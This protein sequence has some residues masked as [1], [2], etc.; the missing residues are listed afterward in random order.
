MPHPRSPR[1]KAGSFRLAEG[2]PIAI[3]GAG[4]KSFDRRLEITAARLR[5]GIRE[6]CGAA[7]AIEG[8]AR[9]E[10]LGPHIVLALSPQISAASDP[11]LRRDGYRLEVG[12]NR[13]RLLG[14]GPAGLRYAV[15]TLLQLVDARGRIPACRIDDG[16]ALRQRGIMLDVSRG[17][18]PTR[19]SLEAL[20][21]FCASL[22]LN[23]LMLYTEHTFRFRRHPEI[24]RNDS[25]LDAATMRHLDAYAADRF[26][27]LVPTLQSLGHMEH[28]LS[29]PAY[30]HLAE[31][32]MGW[33]VA[34][35]EPG[36]YTLLA[37][38]YD[39]YLPN[40]RSGLFNANCDEPWDLGRGR[41]KHENETFGP[42]GLYLEHVRRIRDLARR[43][44]KRTM[45]W[46]DVVHAHPERIPEISRDLVLLD[47]WYEAEFDYD[48]VEVFARHGLEFMV[49]PG[50]SSWNC[51]FPRMQNSLENISRWAD[52]G[53][54]YGAIGLVNTDWGDFGHYNLEGN[55]F[56]AYAWGAQESWSGPAE[57]KDFDKAFSRLVF[58]D[59]RGE[60]ARLYHALG[61]LHDPGFAIF[62]GS[63]LQYLFFDSIESAYFV[64]ACQKGKLRSLDTRLERLR[65]RIQAARKKT[66]RGLLALDEMLYALDATL[67]SVHKALAGLEYVDWRREPSKWK[68][69]ERRALAR[70]LVAL[71]DEQKGLG[72]RLRKLWLSRS[73]I[74]NLDTTRQRLMRSARH[75]RAAARAL[76]M[77]RPGPA[78]AHEP[79][80][81][82]RAIESMRETFD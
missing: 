19:A 61:A 41:S 53:R 26:V 73:Q 67:F 36:T 60:V 35:S 33:T 11:A 6:R 48:R 63:P 23:M 79:V 74:S 47:W 78:P 64:K 16:P 81:H 38:L 29:L 31:T 65:P 17:K 39:E 71:A 58:G 43:H 30:R 49:C 45:I 59:S 62:N 66:T 51:L 27:D 50:T 37:D 15:E 54:R 5:E 7:L 13:I 40:F 25:P 57:K 21:D 9:T 70:R 8:H 46:G 20:I 75:L 12:A 56:L 10:G 55:S 28:V 76:E 14:A 80:D 72:R 1:A 52:A 68:A 22:K 34:P 32:D 82:R 24:G 44:G 3:T 4:T 69:H 2:I 18:V 42:G 77:N